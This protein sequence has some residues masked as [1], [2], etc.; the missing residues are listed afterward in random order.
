MSGASVRNPA[1]LRRATADVGRCVNSCRERRVVLTRASAGSSASARAPPP[2]TAD[3][4]ASSPVTP[5]SAARGTPRPRATRATRR[6]VSVA[7][8]ARRGQLAQE[9]EKALAIADVVP[10]LEPAERGGQ[11]PPDGHERQG[12]EE[13][14][15]RLERSARVRDRA[16][17]RVGEQDLDE[18]EEAGPDEERAHHGRGLAAEHLD[19]PEAVARERREER[20][21]H[22]RER[23]ERE[24]RED[25]DRASHEPRNEVQDDERQEADGGPEQEE[26]DLLLGEEVGRA[27]RDDDEARGGE[28][29]ARGH[30]GDLRAVEGGDGRRRVRELAEIDAGGRGEERRR[31]N[32]RQPGRDPARA[33]RERE[34]EREE[35]GGEER[36]RGV[37]GEDRDAEHA[38]ERR[39]RRQR[40]DEPDGEGERRVEE[41]LARRLR[42]AE[43]RERRRRGTSR[44]RRRGTGTGSPTARARASS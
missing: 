22:E 12:H 19:V 24:R 13:A 35:E 26:A 39:R 9:R 15:G 25:R 10:V 4:S 6:S 31:G 41:R 44:P 27:A 11:A 28:G 38:V 33:A 21:R 37:L 40:E 5:R 43:R 20:G 7:E 23:Q 17:E 3:P 18:R 2:S 34:D 36:A 32:E 16:R 1:R 14:G 29:G 8:R 42:A 30:P